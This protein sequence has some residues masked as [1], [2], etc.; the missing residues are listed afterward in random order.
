MYSCNV[1][2]GGN[3][4]NW[5]MVFLMQKLIFMCIFAHLEQTEP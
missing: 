2:S 4:K 3:K 1:Y 5:I